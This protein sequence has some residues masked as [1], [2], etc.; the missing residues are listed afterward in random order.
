M[1]V[2]MELP[3][4]LRFVRTEP[5]AGIARWIP[6]EDGAHEARRFTRDEADQE[7]ERACRAFRCGHV[8]AEEEPCVSTPSD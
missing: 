2:Y 8:W 6:L 1:F 5:A 3:S 7:V 4:G